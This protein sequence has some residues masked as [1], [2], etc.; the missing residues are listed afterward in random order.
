MNGKKKNGD[1]KIFLK[2]FINIKTAAVI[3]KQRKVFLIF[4]PQ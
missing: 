3:Y 2:T 1:W 4:K